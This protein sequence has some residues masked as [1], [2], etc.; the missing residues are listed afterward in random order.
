MQITRSLANYNT[1]KLITG[2]HSHEM[3]TYYRSLV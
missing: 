1:Q 3:G 2:A